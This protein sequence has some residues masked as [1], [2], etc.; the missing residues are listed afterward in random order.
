MDESGQDLRR[1]VRW[2]DFWTRRFLIARSLDARPL[3]HVGSLA[4][5]SSEYLDAWKIW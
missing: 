5:C 2:L 4:A 1:A 3:G